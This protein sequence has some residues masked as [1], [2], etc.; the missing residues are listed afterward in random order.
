MNLHK[1]LSVIITTILLLLI[2]H[3]NLS[4]VSLNSGQEY[5]N[6][7]MKYAVN[8][9]YEDL[10]PAT[11]PY[12]PA[13][14]TDFRTYSIRPTFYNL[15][16]AAKYVRLEM[17][18]RNESI[19]F[20]YSGPEGAMDILNEAYEHT[21]VPDE[22]ENLMSNWISCSYT[23]K[24]FGSSYYGI[25]FTYL[26]SLEQERELA[27]KITATLASMNLD[28][29]SDFEK[30]EAIYTWICSNVGY[31]HLSAMQIEN[32][33]T[34]S[35]P[36]NQT[37]YGAMCVGSSVCNGF[38]LLCYRMMLEAGI[39][40]RYINGTLHGGRHAWNI[41]KLDDVYF[42]IDSTNGSSD[43][44]Y[45]IKRMKAE[46][47]GRYHL[48]CPKY[49]FFLRG[50]T[51]TESLMYMPQNYVWSDIYNSEEFNEKYPVSDTDYTGEH[52]HD[53][54]GPGRSYKAPTCTEVGYSDAECICGKIFENGVVFAPS[55]H[56][57]DES[58]ICLICGVKKPSYLSEDGKLDVSSMLGKSFEEIFETFKEA[59]PDKNVT[60]SYVVQDYA[61]NIPINE[62]PNY[63]EGLCVIVETTDSVC[64]GLT[65]GTYWSTRSTMTDN[66][67]DIPSP[68]H[69]VSLMECLKDY[70][71]VTLCH[72]IPVAI[73]IEA[74]EKVLKEKGIVYER[75]E[76]SSSNLI[77]IRLQ[78][79]ALQN[80]YVQSTHWT[81][82]AAD[83]ELFGAY[84]GMSLHTPGDVNNDGKIS[85][86][87]AVLILRYLA[88][89]RDENA[90]VNAMDYNSSGGVT[91]LDAVLILRHI[92]GLD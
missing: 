24:N 19:E 28:S 32:N 35:N 37:A 42:V 45:Q 79:E 51:S 92:A 49:D 86:V 12:S 88:N 4:A 38:A 76:E 62:F 67:V 53:K 27:E 44:D 13:W 41:V 14:S 40:C 66:P 10:A 87:D 56:Q 23:D 7:L 6:T 17:K 65:F 47:Y 15:S 74:L 82:N 20:Y 29:K 90:D 1:K 89:F 3:T 70:P 59:F 50:K 61:V 58:G 68:K 36:Y 30:I 46:P 55:G 73:T 9:M 2:I 75:K 60:S 33:I 85:S 34:P 63:K 91:S 22:G 39:D 72:D 25:Y 71:N 69:D 64:N 31:D 57:Y 18:N 52:I 81:Y 54:I 43:A 48:I 77:S 8:P 83:N 80:G 11:A 5:N 21:G 16:E 84:I 78:P 26:T